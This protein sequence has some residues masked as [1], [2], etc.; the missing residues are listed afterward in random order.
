LA[1]KNGRKYAIEALGG[2]ELTGFRFFK[3]AFIEL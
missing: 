2:E 3:G 1:V